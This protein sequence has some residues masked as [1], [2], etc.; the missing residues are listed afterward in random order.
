MIFFISTTFFVLFVEILKDNGVIINLLKPKSLPL[1]YIG[2]DFVLEYKSN[3][4]VIGTD[5]VL[6]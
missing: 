6:F 2:Q 1:T 3:I 5:I 4:F